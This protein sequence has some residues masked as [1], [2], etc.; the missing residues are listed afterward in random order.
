MASI[1]KFTARDLTR[2][3][4]SFPLAIVRSGCSGL[5]KEESGR[6][7]NP[8]SSPSVEEMDVYGDT[9]VRCQSCWRG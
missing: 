4:H 8:W 6:A 2:P 1:H 7:A 3:Y 5:R 9:I